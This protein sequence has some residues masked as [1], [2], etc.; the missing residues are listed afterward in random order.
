MLVATCQAV[1]KTFRFERIDDC[2]DRVLKATQFDRG[3]SKAGGALITP[4]LRPAA[5]GMTVVG[6]PSNMRAGFRLALQER[7]L[8]IEFV[9]MADLP[10]SGGP[11]SVLMHDGS[12]RY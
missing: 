8:L 2:G 7:D 10:P 5:A 3:C 9:I 12:G 11:V 6:L 1:R 4:E